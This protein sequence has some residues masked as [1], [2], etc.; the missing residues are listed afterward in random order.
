MMLSNLCFYSFLSEYHLDFFHVLCTC[1]APDTERNISQ[2]WFSIIWQWI[3]SH[4]HLDQKKWTIN[5]VTVKRTKE[6]TSYHNLSSPCQRSKMSKCIAKD[7]EGKHR[8][9]FES[10][11]RISAN[12]TFSDVLIYYLFI[13]KNTSLIS[14]HQNYLRLIIVHHEQK[15]IFHSLNTIFSLRM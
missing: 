8:A 1:F 7:M 3:K 11:N 12:N 5:L 13:C 4:C 6:L 2:L 14:W 15:I 9:D 10:V